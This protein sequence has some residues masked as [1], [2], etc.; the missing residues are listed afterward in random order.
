MEI[1]QLTFDALYAFEFR[2]GLSVGPLYGNN[3]LLLYFFDNFL[4]IENNSY[5]GTFI[6]F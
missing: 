3:I 5:F 6:I 1:G 2:L 4:N